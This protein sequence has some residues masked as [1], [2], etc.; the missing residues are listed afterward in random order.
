MH[1]SDAIFGNE[2]STGFATVVSFPFEHAS[3]VQ[4]QDNTRMLWLDAQKTG[5][6]TGSIG[7]MPSASLK[8]LLQSET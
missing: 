3:K 6:K 1:Y 8:S 2:L 4:I 7:T 5:K